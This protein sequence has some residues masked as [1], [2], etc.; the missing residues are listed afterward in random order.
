MSLSN[1]E[2]AS[3]RTYGQP[4]VLVSPD[5][6]AKL[7]MPVVDHDSLHRYFTNVLKIPY[8]NPTRVLL[9][10]DTEMPSDVLGWYRPFTN[11]I[12][13]NAV[14]SE[15]DYTFGGGVM[16]VIAHEGRHLADHRNNKT[17]VLKELG[18]KAFTSAAP[19]AA[20]T[21]T[22]TAEMSL[23]VSAIAGGASVIVGGVASRRYSGK[24]SMLEKRAQ[25][26]ESQFA[27][28]HS[29]HQTDILFPLSERS[30]W[31]TRSRSLGKD[32]VAKLERGGMEWKPSPSF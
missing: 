31:L 20:T 23:P 26:E 27:G 22:V 1:Y 7:G 17:L 10:S 11:K 9:E 2:M 8:Q 5:A 24:H 6:S 14:T 19:F 28:L 4:E 12:H 16:R 13:I 25:E 15:T 3:G 21:V 30:R 18:M 32:T 29:G